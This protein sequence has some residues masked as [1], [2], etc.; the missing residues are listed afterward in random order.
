M[1]LQENIRKILRE[2]TE[3][4]KYTRA[5][6]IITNTIKD[7]DYVCDIKVRYYDAADT[8]E[9]IVKID[10]KEMET[11]FEKL[12]IWYAEELIKEYLSDLRKK[13]EKEIKD[14]LP[15]K[16]LVYIDQFSCNKKLNESEDK[17]SRLLSSI[18]QDGLYQVM[19]YAR[20]SLQQ[21][22]SKTG[23]LPREVYEKFIRD[24]I[25]EEGYY[26]PNGTVQLGYAVEIKK[27]IQ[28]DGF[29]MS[30]DKVTVEIIGYDNYERQTEGYIESLS[31]LSDEEIS[32]IVN[33][34]I[35]WVI[36]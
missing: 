22:I 28:I 6:E 15:V 21:I 5:L 34:L 27:N 8:Y 30:G 4:G 20:L 14:F 1:N 29:Y 10:K 12:S 33:D 26:Q 13:V 31:N 17:K 18:E 7:E 35:L 11:N 25:N 2:E 24:C 32:V 19:K 3:S 23:K 9:V 36:E 16:V